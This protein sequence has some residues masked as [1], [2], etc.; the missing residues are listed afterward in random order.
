MHNG[1]QQLHELEHVRER[2]T[3]IGIISIVSNT[4]GNRHIILSSN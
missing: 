1:P 2:V 4:V 3:S